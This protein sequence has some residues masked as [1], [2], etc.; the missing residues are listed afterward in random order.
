MLKIAKIFANMLRYLYGIEV[1]TYLFWRFSLHPVHYQQ[2]SAFCF[3]KCL[4]HPQFA[5]YTSIQNKFLPNLRT[6]SLDI[7]TSW[8][9][10][11]HF[12]TLEHPKF[13]SR[14]GVSVNLRFSL[15]LFDDL[16]A[17]QIRPSSVVFNSCINSLGKGTHWHQARY[18]HQQ[19]GVKDMGHF[20][21][22]NYKHEQEFGGIEVEVRG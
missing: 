7:S 5:L 14:D 3:E 12:S 8:C 21:P 4:K 11:L 20:L 15:C 13:V 9:I 1:L 16:Q 10:K 19:K 18:G 17:Q 22:P 6:N 2:P